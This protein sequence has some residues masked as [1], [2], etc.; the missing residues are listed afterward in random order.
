VQAL[1]KSGVEAVSKARHSAFLVTTESN[2]VL[3]EVRVALSIVG[4]VQPSPI[5]AEQLFRVAM[6]STELELLELD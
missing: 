5:L 3:Q 1:D 2:F 4:T 6:V